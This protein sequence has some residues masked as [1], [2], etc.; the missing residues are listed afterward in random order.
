M[1]K[2]TNKQ[3]ASIHLA[4]QMLAD[5]LNSAGLDQR[6][7]LKPSV[8][9]PWTKQAVKDQLFK[10]IMNALYRKESTTELNK[11]EEIDETW[12]TL[13]RHLGEKFGIEY[14]PIPSEEHL[15][16]FFAG[17]EL[18]GKNREKYDDEFKEPL[19]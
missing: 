17:L 4:F 18:A 6:T 3:N 15:S 19:L 8:S 10:P 13:M 11:I 16:E 12:D 9:I 7:V 1:E 5:S 14:I 2:R